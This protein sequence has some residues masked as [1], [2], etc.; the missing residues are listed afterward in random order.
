[1]TR[2]LV[3]DGHAAR[4][5]FGQNFLRDPRVIAGIVGAL[6]PSPDDNI[7][8]IGPGL[9]ALTVPVSARVRKLR[10]IELD[11]DLAARLRDDPGLA[12]RL[13]IHEADALRFDFRSVASP[14]NPVRIFGNLPY[15]ISTPLMLR[16]FAQT[17]VIRDM[18][19]MLQKEVA[20]RLAAA[21]GS[22]DYG[23]LSVI[24]QYHCRVI[25]VMEVAPGA[26]RPVPKV[27]SAVVRLVPH[28]VKPCEARDVKK[29]EQVLAAAFGQRRKALRNSL[30]ALFT[31]AELE[32]CGV[33]PG[34]R[35]ENIPPA[36]Y[37]R[38]ADYL[39]ERESGSNG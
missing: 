35:A 21:P 15:N 9:G 28:A 38:L 32:R 14:E 8:E 3:T 25:P 34:A 18:H 2:D 29:L 23:R 37:C 6:N 1:M 7:A 12:P 11:R 33:S 24:T 39:T 4:R 5:R 27:T 19:F 10:V 20:L 13:E 17:D 22:K 36:G 30:G 26:F 16:L 31:G